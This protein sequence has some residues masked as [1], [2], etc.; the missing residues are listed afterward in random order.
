MFKGLRR[1]GAEA[2]PPVLPGS[3][4]E[5]RCSDRKRTARS[6]IRSI[7]RYRVPAAA[8][9]GDRRLREGAIP[10]P[11]F[12]TVARAAAGGSGSGA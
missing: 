3:A 7:R 11:S 5:P 10:A 6:P 8:K 1:D 4:P 2:M 12:P 9:G